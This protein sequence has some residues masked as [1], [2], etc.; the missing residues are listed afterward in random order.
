MWL[1]LFFKTRFAF[2]HSLNSIYHFGGTDNISLSQ[3]IKFTY[4]EKL[5]EKYLLNSEIENSVKD[6][7]YEYYTSRIFIIVSQ[8]L[9]YGN[10]DYC[11]SLLNKCDKTKKFKIRWYRL[12]IF[13]F[14]PNL[15]YKLLFFLWKIIKKI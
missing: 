7:L 5:L 14:F 15:L 9:F 4:F 2:C 12:Y 6:D 1:K 13:S 10:Q 11:R 8:S 3:Y